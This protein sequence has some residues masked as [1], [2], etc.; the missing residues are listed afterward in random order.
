MVTPYTQ[1]MIVDARWKYVWNMGDVDECYDLV[2]DP[3]ERRNLAVS[4]DHDEARE[5][6]RRLQRQL[7][8]WMSDTHD[9]VL[10][11]FARH[12]TLQGVA[13]EP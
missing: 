13:P 3:Y 9:Q 7:L 12:L 5:A 2:T 10:R 8:G 4:P 1:R 6:Q 11:Y